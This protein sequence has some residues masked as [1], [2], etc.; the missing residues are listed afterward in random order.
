MQLGDKKKKKLYLAIRI[1]KSS[2][3]SVTTFALL[4]RIASS[5]ENIILVQ[6]AKLV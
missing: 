1:H 4:P 6:C 3:L 5:F 2:I